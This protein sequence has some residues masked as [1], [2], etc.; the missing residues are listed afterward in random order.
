V[1]SRDTPD[2]PRAGPAQPTAK[3]EPCW[4]ILVLG[5][6]EVAD[7]LPLLDPVKIVTRVFREQ[8]RGLV[9]VAPEAAMYW[10][11]RAGVLARTL[12]M[13]GRLV[14]EDPVVGTKIINSSFANTER[15]LPRASGLTMLFDSETARITALIDAAEIS[16]LRTA[17]VA[18]LSVQLLGRP[19]AT[20]A[21]VIGTGVIG[22]A[23]AR[24]LCERLPNLRQL[25]LCDRNVSSAEALAGELREM[26]LTPN[27]LTVSTTADPRAAIDD[28]EIV[29]TC[30]TVDRPY[31]LASWLSPGTLVVNLSLDD[32]D[33]EVF[34]SADKIVVDCWDLVRSDGRRQLGRMYREK[35]VAGPGGEGGTVK[36]VDAEIKDVLMDPARLGRG[37]DEEVIVV[38]PFGMSVLDLAIAQEAYRLASRLSGQRWV[39]L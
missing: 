26:Q 14:G 12:N 38:N 13:P 28:A 22:R 33:R 15:G 24:L 9:V 2:T 29:A 1:V 25:D 4:E 8:A 23:T 34:F 21:A 17:A 19:A 5:T 18:T 10:E 3:A 35:A 27:D 37:G 6:Q 39:D 31:V 32:L 7:L 16:A 20:R 36:C 11:A 30:T